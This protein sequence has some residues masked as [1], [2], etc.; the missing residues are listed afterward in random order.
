MP[1]VKSEAESN[2]RGL[3][4]FN[5]EI[6]FGYLHQGIIETIEKIKEKIFLAVMRYLL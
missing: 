2:Y 6:N 4:F 3:I 1:A 5:L